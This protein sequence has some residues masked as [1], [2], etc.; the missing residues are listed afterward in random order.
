MARTPKG[1]RQVRAEAVR[2]ARAEA[3][4]REMTGDPEGAG[5]LRDLAAAIRRIRLTSD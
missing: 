4:E 2:L 5:V 3:R 1:A